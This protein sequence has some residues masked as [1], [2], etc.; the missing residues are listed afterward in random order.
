MK[1]LKMICKQRAEKQLCFERWSKTSITSQTHFVLN[2]M[3]LKSLLRTAI[4]ILHFSTDS[5]TLN[6]FLLFKGLIYI[7]HKEGLNVLN[8][9]ASE[10]HFNA[11]FLCNFEFR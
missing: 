2:K 10:T 8:Q 9:N 4:L 3:V 5:S 11:N 1:N 7:L 6:P